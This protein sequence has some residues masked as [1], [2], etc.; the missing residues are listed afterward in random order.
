MVVPFANGEEALRAVELIER[1]AA[2]R[3]VSVIVV[4]LTGA[5]IDEAF[6]AMTL[7]QI[8]ET[9][10]HYEAE[11]ILA[12]VS[13]LSAAAVAG[14]DRQPLAVHKDLSEAVAAAFQVATA[15]RILV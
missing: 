11:T 3:D 10:E 15:Q 7:E 6:G 13:P 9:A 14:L 4:D 2:A 5:V 12:A 8:I 1:D